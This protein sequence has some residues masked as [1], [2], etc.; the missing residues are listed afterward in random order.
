MKQLRD[1]FKLAMS[2]FTLS[3][4]FL[5]DY[6]LRNGMTHFYLKSSGPVQKVA[7]LSVRMND[8]FWKSTNKVVTAVDCTHLLSQISQETSLC[9]LLLLFASWAREVHLSASCFYI[10][11]SNPHILLST[12]H[13]VAGKGQPNSSTKTASSPLLPCPCPSVLVPITPPCPPAPAVAWKAVQPA[14]Q[15]QRSI[16]KDLIRLIPLNLSTLAF[17][18]GRDSAG[19]ALSP[20]EVLLLHVPYKESPNCYLTP[21]TLWILNIPSETYICNMNKY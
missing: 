13:M 21:K 6:W 14:R 18:R 20:C 15:C 16:W 3:T 2:Q 11:T 17:S 8:F 10:S 9:S 4:A 12:S 7:Q 5:S 1:Q 19:P